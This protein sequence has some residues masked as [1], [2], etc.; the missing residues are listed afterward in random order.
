VSADLEAVRIRRGGA[1]VGEH[2]RCWARHQTVTDPE[3]RKAAEV[4]RRAYQDQR[5]ADRRDPSDGEVQQRDLS[6]YDQILGS[7]DDEIGEAA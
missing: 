2:P 7:G 4:M 3:H 6:S 5:R 1:L